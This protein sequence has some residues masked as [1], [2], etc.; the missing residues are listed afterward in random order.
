MALRSILVPVRPAIGAMTVGLAWAWAL[1]LPDAP[2]APVDTPFET[3]ARVLLSPRCRNCHPAGDRPLQGDEGRPH[4]MEVGRAAVALGLEC[5]SCHFAGALAGPG[6]PPGAPNW[7]LPP[8]GSMVFEGR[9]PAQLCAQLK[10][11]RETNGKSLA[12]VLHHVEED[13]L[14]RWGWSPGEGRTPPPVPHEDF[15]AAFRAW[16]EAGAP[17]PAAANE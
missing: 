2:A 4:D 9:T 14:V 5:G 11:P 3:V 1:L 12:E 13:P 15:V 8:P 16:M 7:H 17:C 6:M 10:D